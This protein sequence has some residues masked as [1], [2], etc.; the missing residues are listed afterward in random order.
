MIN[1]W[2]RKKFKKRPYQTVLQ[3]WHG[4]MLKKIA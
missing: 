4:T 3:T 1:D 2:M